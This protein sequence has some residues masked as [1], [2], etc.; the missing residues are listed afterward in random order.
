MTATITKRTMKKTIIVLGMTLLFYISSVGQTSDIEKI[1][2]NNHLK[3][4]EQNI[5]NETNFIETANGKTVVLTSFI[6]GCKWILE[7]MA[8]YNKL[9]AEH[10]NKFEVLITFADD[11]EPMSKYIQDVNFNF[12]YIY[13]PEKL[14]VKK[15]ALN[16]TIYTVL[17][18]STGNIQEKSITGKLNRDLI[19]NQ[20]NRNQTKPN[21]KK[22]SSS[23]PILNCQLKRYELGDEVLRNF[24]SVDLPSKIITG[25]KANESIDT[26]ENIRFCNITGENILG[27]YSCAYDLPKS[28]FTYDKEIE[29]I[30]SHAPNHR[31]SLSLSVS[32]LHA[33]FNQMLIHQID[34]NFGLESSQVSKESDILIL[35]QINVEKG[36]IRIS[37]ALDKGK[38]S[39][40]KISEVDF[41]I[42]ATNINAI[43]IA[44]L[45]EEATQLPVEINV[46]PNIL[47]ILDISVENKEKTI[48][49]LIKLL[50]ENG[51]II[52]KDKKE[53]K[54]V[55]I[56]MANR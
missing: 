31:Y 43:E 18:D 54:K 21:L 23:L 5:L 4:L 25:Y 40:N 20:L 45:I 53:V 14:L 29:Y 2:V 48:D 46:A 10:P 27:L 42:K 13:D 50:S 36:N 35:S 44:R 7:E 33:D 34:L 17:F 11:I 8:F 12:I 9:K 1:F 32:N 51:L 15:L 19:S 38:L 39:N 22:S 6:N 3:Q 30:N 49:Y 55:E 26:T 28:R 47:Y 41:Q 37:N 52:N 56:K 16:D 24:S